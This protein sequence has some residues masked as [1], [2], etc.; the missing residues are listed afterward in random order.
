MPGLYPAAWAG[1]QL[2]ADA[3]PPY[4]GG[5]GPRAGA[6]R[7]RSQVR[8][9][10][11]AGVDRA[12]PY[13]VMKSA[14]CERTVEALHA[15]VPAPEP[16]L[17]SSWLW[18][19]CRLHR[20]RRLRR[21]V[22]VEQGERRHGLRSSPQ[23]RVRGVWKGLSARILMMGALTA[24]RWFFQDSLKVSFK[25]PRPLAPQAPESLKNRK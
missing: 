18:P 14:C 19:S 3:A 2:S 17:R 23:T 20:R 22:R 10:G 6:A 12:D 25:L 5:D 8:R 21:R 13:T 24:L 9:G 7:P 1:A 11:P 4:G 15:P 16:V